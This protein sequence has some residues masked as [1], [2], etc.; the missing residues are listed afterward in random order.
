MLIHIKY[1]KQVGRISMSNFSQGNL[2]NEISK[3]YPYGEFP[4]QYTKKQKELDI[5]KTNTFNYY[6]NEKFQQISNKV[7]T[8][9][10]DNKKSEIN[11]SSNINL[12]SILPLLSNFNNEKKLD[13][14][15]LLTTLLPIML[16]KNSKD[17]TALLKL[18]NKN[19]LICKIHI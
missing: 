3:M 4:T 8:Q 9:S 11:N 16:G 19:N 18:F 5:N 12:H 10:N 15:Q 6:T 13:S 17:I 2:Y 7:E 14:N 1:K